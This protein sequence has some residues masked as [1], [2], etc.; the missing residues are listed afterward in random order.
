MIRFILITLFFSLSASA[1]VLNTK[2]PRPALNREI[3]L[4]SQIE[5]YVDKVELIRVSMIK[6]TLKD[7]LETIRSNSNIAHRESVQAVQQ[8]ILV[9]RYSSSFFEQIKS[10]FLNKAIGEIQA[11]TQKLATDFGFDLAEGSNIVELIFRQSYIILTQLQDA[12]IPTALKSEIDKIIPIVG[13]AIAISSTG[14]R[15]NAYKAG[16][17]VYFKIKTLYDAFNKISLS[18]SSFSLVQELVELNEFYSNY[19]QVNSRYTAGGQAK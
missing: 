3:Q 1:Q 11:S 7:A 6:K 2:D 15:P 19:A 9:I 18:Q 17:D 13:R 12:D 16:D 14:D 4:L 8:S 5:S 10:T